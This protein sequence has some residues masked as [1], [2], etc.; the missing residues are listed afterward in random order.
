[1][2]LMRDETI[3]AAEAVAS[4]L[5]QRAAFT[6]LGAR[7]R[8]LDP[9]FVVV[10]AR[11]SSSH[12]GTYL[13]V[14]LGK[15]LGLVAAAAMPSIASVYHRPQ[16]LHGALFIAISQSGGS[17]DVLASAE[18]ARAAGALT[19]A[20]VNNAASPLAQACEHVLDMAAGPERSVAA[21]K[22]V[23]ASLA[24]SLALVDAWQDG[25]PAAAA[26]AALPTRLAEATALDWSPLTHVLAHTDR[27]FAVGRGPAL[28]IAKEAALK[29]AET[30]GIAGMAFS[31]AELAHGP[32]A[33]AGPAFP[34][35]A[36]LQ[37]DASRPHSEQLLAGLAARGAA[38]LT[39]GG[40]VAGATALPVLPPSHPDADLLPALV[41]FYLAAEAAARRRGLDPDRPPALQK[42]TRTI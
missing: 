29:L 28:G 26:L 15:Q 41:S 2:T 12:A 40:T 21:T 9:P 35:L 27:I 25:A 22:T 37:N 31:A 30:C 33:L 14:L 39:A 24:A 5:A 8:A 7:L 10:C 38:V 42:V 32:M 4:C 11:G 23:L 1:M 6:A 36:F 20:I 13:R 17:P 16:R 18:Q 34:V 3:A 19:L